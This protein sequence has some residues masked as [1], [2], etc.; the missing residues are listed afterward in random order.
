MDLG[1]LRAQRLKI[2]DKSTYQMGLNDKPE[3]KKQQKTLDRKALDQAYEDAKDEKIKQ[4]KENNKLD[5]QRVKEFLE[6]VPDVAE[7]EEEDDDADYFAKILKSSNQNRS[8]FPTVAAVSMRYGASNRMTAAIATA[9]MIDLGLVTA[10]D[11][12]KVLDHNK[13]AREKKRIMVEL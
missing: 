9:T 7:N 3:S 11:R 10:D 6:E 5:G 4:D 12:S 1:F 13:V 2:G 8:E